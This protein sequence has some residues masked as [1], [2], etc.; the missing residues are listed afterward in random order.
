MNAAYLRVGLMIVASLGLAVGLV[1]FLGQN[2]VHDGLEFE[3]YFSES[4]QGLDVGSPVKL[5]GVQLGQVTDIL[6]ASAA[7]REVGNV[8][9][10]AHRVVVVRYAIDP[11]RLGSRDPD[12][13]AAVKAGLRA[14]LAAQGITGL[15]Y[16]ELDFVDPA[17][18]P[19]QRIDWT[20]QRPVIPSVPST[21]SQIQD[22]AQALATKLRDV[23]IAGMANA[24]ETLANEAR[25]Q[26]SH[27]DLR[28]AL[29][30]AAAVMESV[31]QGVD[32]AD[33]GALGQELRDTLAA[34]RELAGGPQSRE[35]MAAT[36]KT[37]ERLSEAA[38]RL[39]ALITTLEATVKRA[40]HGTADLQSQ[41]TPILRDVRAIAA[42][43][44]DTSETLRRYPAG[45][46]L[47]GPP[48][49]EGGR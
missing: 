44:R 6:L 31:K 16:V 19:P 32:A 13:A 29:R 34:V 8:E 42:N 4:V 5:R 12:V 30:D 37:A 10:P 45:S 15:A 48:P 21:I 9:D 17:R 43:L 28:T 36:T 47:G 39:P 23:D 3:S 2:R 41:L 38:A 25:N 18:F 14:R 1:L 49:R 22:A 35:L 40:N 24:I 26:L 11:R 7:Y 27:G 20:P 33:I 46:L